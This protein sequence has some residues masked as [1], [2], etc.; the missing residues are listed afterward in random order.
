MN[1]LSEQFPLWPQLWPWILGVGLAWALMWVQKGPGNRGKRVRGVSLGMVVV[2]L[3]LIGFPYVGRG[4]AVTWWVVW[5]VS[6]SMGESDGDRSRWDRAQRAWKKMKKNLQ[7]APHFRLGAAWGRINE[8]DLDR[9]HPTDPECSGNVLRQALASNP[10]DAVLLFSDGKWPDVD[11][12]GVPLYCVGV[13]ESQ[14]AVDVAVE[15]VHSPPFAFAGSTASVTARISAQGPAQT[16]SVSLLLGDHGVASR[17]VD[18]TGGS[19]TVTFEW[20]PSRAGTTVAQVR[21]DPVPNEKALRNNVRRFFIDIRRDRV[22]TL[23]I[24]GQPG[25]HYNFLRAQ[26]KND[27]AVD[28][29]SFVVLRD[30]D[31]AAGYGDRDL[32]LIPF[33]TPHALVSQL[34]SF[35][36]VILEEWASLKFA[37][38]P[39]FL[40]ALTKW[41]NAGGGVLFVEDPPFSQS[42][43]PWL[44][45]RG[46]PGP[47]RFSLVSKTVGHPLVS[48]GGNDEN[49]LDKM[50][51]LEGSGMFPE[52]IMP[53]AR[54]LAVEPGGHPVMAEMPWGRGRVLGLANRTS[55]RW[56]L[57]GGRRGKGPGDYQRFWENVVRWLAAS[58][59]AGSVRVDRP[60]GS[61][62]VGETTLLAVHAFAEDQTSPRLLAR[63]SGETWKPLPLRKGNRPGQYDAEFRPAVPGPYEFRLL[64]GKI[65]TDRFWIDVS[66]GW[67]EQMDLR[68]DL[69]RLAER[70]RLSGGEFVTASNFNKRVWAR[71]NR[72]LIKKTSSSSF[73]TLFLVPGLF[74][75]LGEWVW[76]RRKG[77]V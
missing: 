70:A 64:S 57:E 13:G 44:G 7:G 32:S 73:S 28:L 75:L 21:V 20:I 69:P 65:D 74:M 36:V 51:A 12:M 62:S 11:P 24:S 53:G 63:P 9:I 66:S 61:V 77:I 46:V 18:L 47:V 26:L 41:V 22:R 10:P 52:K 76:R 43:S 49:F 56:A 42:L 5:D 60:S 67:D 45:E 68:P 59:G 14:P 23:Y 35:S 27:P 2:G 25:P 54:V 1:F 17:Q 72:R 37:L 15:A 34:P 3:L 48:M 40:G 38:G 6:S 4:K 16:V 58:P 8:T 30:P 50:G 39:A 29:V 55:W 19:N 31:D 71:W 33:P